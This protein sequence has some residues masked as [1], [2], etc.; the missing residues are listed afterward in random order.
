MGFGAEILLPAEEEGKKTREAFNNLVI[1][2]VENCISKEDVNGV[3]EAF[4][5]GFDTTD[6]FPEFRTTI[7]KMLK[8]CINWTKSKSQEL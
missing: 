1:L 5:R 6:A 3:V 7:D 2:I 8:S 4:C